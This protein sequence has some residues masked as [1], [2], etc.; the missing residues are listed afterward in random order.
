MPIS[1]TSWIVNMEKI[2][3]LGVDDSNLILTNAEKSI[4]KS[5]EPH[6]LNYPEYHQSVCD[7]KNMKVISGNMYSDCIVRNLRMCGFCFDSDKQK[8][9]SEVIVRKVLVS[10]QDAREMQ[11]Y[12]G[13]DFSGM[14]WLEFYGDDGELELKLGCIIRH[15]SPFI[16]L[17]IVE[18]DNKTIDWGN[19]T[20][21]VIF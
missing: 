17:T 9:K 5:W 10:L 1:T 21:L 12:Y 20:E 13:D 11:T 4:W 16:E 6:I 3:E 8:W 18:M 7:I 19:N 14:L 15:V 2:L